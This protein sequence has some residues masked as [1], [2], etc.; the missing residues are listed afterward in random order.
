MIDV[1]IDGTANT[2]LFTPI[3]PSGSPTLA[4]GDVI[5]GY[6]IQNITWFIAKPQN[7]DYQYW[8]QFGNIVTP[9]NGMPNY[10]PAK[11]FWGVRIWLT[12]PRKFYDFKLVDVY[13][14]PTWTNNQAGADIAITTLRSAIP[15]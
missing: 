13:D 1:T 8:T 4:P 9:G 12:G 7:F 11:E 14:Q 15:A 3:D 5:S 10:I 2:I 6:N